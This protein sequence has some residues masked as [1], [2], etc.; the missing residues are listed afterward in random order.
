MKYIYIYIYINVKKQDTLYFIIPSFSANLQIGQHFPSTC[1]GFKHVIGHVA[2]TQR[3][4][5]LTQEHD[6]QASTCHFSPLR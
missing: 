6:V 5:P 3:A 2:A 1:T 4:R